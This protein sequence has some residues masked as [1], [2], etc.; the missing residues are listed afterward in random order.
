MSTW[1]V[2]EN[3]LKQYLDKLKPVYHKRGRSIIM[4]SGSGKSYWMENLQPVKNAFI[5]ADPLM[6]AVGAMPPL[7]GENISGL[8]WKEHMQQIC[9]RCD[10]VTVRCKQMGLWLMGA[11]WWLHNYID[12]FVILP[13][14]LNKRYLKG[15][16]DKGEGFEK[17]YYENEV[18]PYINNT[19]RP[20]A[21]DHNI[22]VFDSIEKCAKWVVS[23]EPTAGT[24]RGSTAKKYYLRF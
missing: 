10:A 19:L 3:L 6:W 15:K 18:L 9:E 1:K 4:P 17:G 23:R 8:N 13:A 12:A 20:T 2:P 11:T 21:K 16:D 14:E 22:P 24:A 5:D 7:D